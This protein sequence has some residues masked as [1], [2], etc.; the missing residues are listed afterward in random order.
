MQVAVV[1]H[2]IAWEDK[3]RNHDVVE[4]M[5]ESAGVEPGTYVVL[6]EL[7]DT[8]FSFDL[9]AIVD[10]RSLPWACDLAR[11][12]SIWLQAGFAE[13]GPD[14]LTT[15]HRVYRH[16]GELVNGIRDP[17]QGAGADNFP[18]V[19][20]QE[21]VTTAGDNVLVRMIEGLVIGF[22][23]LPVHLDPLDVEPLEGALVSGFVIDDLHG[24]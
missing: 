8:G 12:K 18:A 20:R 13:R 9:D 21:D 7:G 6:P 17:K 22:F 4:S 14:S 16:L 11:R 24:P 23:E 2:D 10:D 15:C 3:P 5:L 1:Q 19:E